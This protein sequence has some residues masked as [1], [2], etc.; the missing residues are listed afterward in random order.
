[1]ATPNPVKL[2]LRSVSNN[3]RCT[4]A[5]WQRYAPSVLAAYWAS[6][7]PYIFKLPGFSVQSVVSKL[8]DAVRGKLAFDYPCPVSNEALA[9]WWADTIVK[10]YGD[11][12][13]IGPRPVKQTE[14]IEPESKN[15]NP[16]FFRTMSQRHAAMFAELL[17]AGLV[18][19]PI[20]IR[21][22]EADPDISSMFNVDLIHLPD[23]T[24]QII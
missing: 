9:S 20:T 10:P 3:P 16:Y 19:G 12:V 13:Y 18:Q 2:E 1:M 24:L 22:V 17:N 6:P 14:P 15:K 5:A 11:E 7:E 23:G 21:R 8:R 4:L